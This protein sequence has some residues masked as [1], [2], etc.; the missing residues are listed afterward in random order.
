MARR[1]HLPFKKKKGKTSSHH[2]YPPQ[3]KHR[4]SPTRSPSGF[5]G[6]RAPCPCAST[7]RRMRAISGLLP[8]GEGCVCMCVGAGVCACAAWHRAWLSFSLCGGVVR[9]PCPDLFTCAYTHQQPHSFTAADPLF[10]ER[11]DLAAAPAP[12]E[13]L[14]PPGAKAQ[15][16]QGGR[17]SLL[18]GGRTRWLQEQ[19]QGGGERG[20]GM[21][22]QTATGEYPVSRFMNVTLGNYVPQVSE[23]GRV[24]AQQNQDRLLCRGDGVMA[25]DV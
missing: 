5:C 6:K 21:Q 12:T 25:F 9:A 14:K 24:H 3:K 16:E 20:L 22:W 17:R 8:D 15:A 18:R 2:P 23:G 7:T 13:A 11:P 1:H 10:V 19:D 4:R